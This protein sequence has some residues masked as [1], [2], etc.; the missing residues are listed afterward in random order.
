MARAAENVVISAEPIVGLSKRSSYQNAEWQ[1][2]IVTFDV[3][4]TTPVAPVATVLT[5]SPLLAWWFIPISVIPGRWAQHSM[6][7]DQKVGDS[8]DG[9]P[10]TGDHAA[11]GMQSF[12]CR[13]FLQFCNGRFNIIFVKT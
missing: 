10:S 11:C 4:G 5:S 7:P 6:L 8:H 9:Q 13:L 2:R 1:R 3:C 12:F